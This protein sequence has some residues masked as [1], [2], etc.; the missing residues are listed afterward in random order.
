MIPDPASVK[1]DTRPAVSDSGL[2]GQLRLAELLAADMFEELG[3][4]FVA[5]AGVGVWH[6]R[7]V[8]GPQPGSGGPRD[9]G[10]SQRPQC[11][12]ILWMNGAHRTRRRRMSIVCEAREPGTFGTVGACQ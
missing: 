1:A 9:G 4:D 10:S 8:R 5:D 7:A 6:R 2:P 11:S 3:G 12:R